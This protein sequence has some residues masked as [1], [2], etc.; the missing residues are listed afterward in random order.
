MALH[1]LETPLS[2]DQ[3]HEE[4]EDGYHIRATVIESEQ[5][6]CWL[7]GHGRDI[8][9]PEPSELLNDKD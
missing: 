1:L 8:C 6:R 3:I 7:R 4:M 2:I 9:V 5:L